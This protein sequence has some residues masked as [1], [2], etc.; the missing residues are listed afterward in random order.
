MS[1]SLDTNALAQQ[2]KKASLN[3]DA[4]DVSDASNDNVD[5]KHRVYI[6]NL[7]FETT[8]GRIVY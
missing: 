3:D 8:E 4:H 7:S 2:I 5:D 6:G 1:A